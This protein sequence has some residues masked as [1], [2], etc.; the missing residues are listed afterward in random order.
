M[1]KL[2]LAL[3]ITALYGC[4]V[5]PP[6]QTPVTIK[7]STDKYSG[8]SELSTS[9]IKFNLARSMDLVKIEDKSTKGLSAILLR[10]YRDS[11]NDNNQAE[12]RKWLFINNKQG[13]LAIDSKVYALGTG[14]HHG[15]TVVKG[16]LHLIEVVSFTFKPEMIGRLVSAHT[17]SGKV[18]DS[19]FTLTPEQVK[20]VNEFALKAI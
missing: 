12:W 8:I 17:I 4:S 13:Y 20:S 6:S 2:T 7:E 19:E 10:Y 11:A 15:E 18:G 9:R 1:K 5:A 3:L 14:S 16:G